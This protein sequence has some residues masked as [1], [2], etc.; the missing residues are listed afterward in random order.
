MLAAEF[1]ASAEMRE[2]GAHATLRIERIRQPAEC[3]RFLLGRAQALRICQ[4]NL[5]LPSA[6]ANLAE[7]EEDVATEVMKAGE[8]A[9]EIVALSGLLRRLEQ[10]ERFGKPLGNP[11]TLDKADLRLGRAHLVWRGGNSI[12]KRLDRH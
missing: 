11:Q 5:M 1:D 3:A 12:A 2:G 9:Y 10:L 6:A 8:F 4:A 7:R